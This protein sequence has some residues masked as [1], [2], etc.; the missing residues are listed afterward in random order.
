MGHVDT[1]CNRKQL[2]VQLLTFHAKSSTYG[3]DHA[4]EESAIPI[5]KGSAADGSN[6][7]VPEMALPLNSAP[8]RIGKFP[9]PSRDK[10]LNRHPF[11]LYRKHAHTSTWRKSSGS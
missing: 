6:Q 7:T 8:I 9:R 3:V 5:I 10:P 2:Y 4:Q 1:I 11:G